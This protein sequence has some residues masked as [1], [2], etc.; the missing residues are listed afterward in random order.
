[1]LAEYGL[2]AS[3]AQIGMNTE[4]PF[5]DATFDVVFSSHCLEHSSDLP[6]TFGEIARVLKPGGKL[7][8]AVP[9]GFD[10]SDEHLFCLDIDGWLAAT[11]LA[12]FD[13][14]TV[15]LGHAYVAS[16][17]LFVVA[18]R[19]AADVNLPALASLTSRYSKVGKTF[20]PAASAI[21]DYHGDVV[22]SGA[23]RILASAGA[24]ATISASRPIGAVLMFRHRWSSITEFKAGHETQT[25]DLYSRVPYIQTITIDSLAS[26]VEIRVIGSS[27]GTA[28]AVIHGVML[29]Q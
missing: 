7:I 4:L 25:C 17:D 19:Q 5:R 24:T 27:R 3:N 6:R 14:L 29:E 13:I 9:F 16:G 21:F 1:M 26:K 20:V 11:E 12:G 8:F 28:Q 15:H 10:D 2:P 23:H 18:T 22:E